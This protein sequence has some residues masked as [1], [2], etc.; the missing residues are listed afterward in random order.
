MQRARAMFACNFFACGGFETIDNQGFK[1][2]EEGIQAVL[3]RKPEFTVICSSDEEYAT[4]VPEIFSKIKDM[5]QVVVAG[6]P[7]CM[8]ELKS[9]GIQHF[10]HIR[11]NLLETL[12]K[13]QATLKIS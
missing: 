8:E 3:E 13:F 11:S 12:Q 4:I 7:A 1:S 5:T 10:I 2:L 9:V 6:A